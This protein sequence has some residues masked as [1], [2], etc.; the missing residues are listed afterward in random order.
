MLNKQPDQWN[1]WNT[2][3]KIIWKP[4]Q[5]NSKLHVPGWLAILFIYFEYCE[6]WYRGVKINQLYTL[7]ALDSRNYGSEEQLRQ[8]K[9]AWLNKGL[10]HIADRENADLQNADL[11]LHR[12]DKKKMKYINI[13]ILN[14][15]FLTYKKYICF[16]NYLCTKYSINIVTIVFIQLYEI[17][18]LKT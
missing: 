9:F 11:S 14:Y 6:W 18:H 7:R 1:D 3:K 2:R 5:D 15:I 4:I 10:V 13:F 16:H 12:L 8:P 17:L